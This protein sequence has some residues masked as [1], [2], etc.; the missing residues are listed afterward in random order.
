MVIL[1]SG[2]NLSDELAASLGAL[3]VG[4]TLAFLGEDPLSGRTVLQ[5]ELANDLTEVSYL[6][7]SDR[8]G[9]LTQ[10]QEERVEPNTKR[11]RDVACNPFTATLAYIR[12]YSCKHYVRYKT[13]Q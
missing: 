10:V 3:P 11:H 13:Q 8:V 4:C 5:R 9:R 12:E 6:D 7:I 1:A 2:S